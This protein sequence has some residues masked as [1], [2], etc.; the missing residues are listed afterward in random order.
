MGE[1]AFDLLKTGYSR[2]R[3][4]KQS[5][6]GLAGLQTI[7]AIHPDLAG[8][9]IHRGVDRL[10][11]K[12]GTASSL[13]TISKGSRVV[14]INPVEVTFCRAT[15]TCPWSLEG[16]AGYTRIYFS[17]GSRQVSGGCW[18]PQKAT[19]VGCGK[20]KLLW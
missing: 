5:E 4:A 17:G 3:S 11:R 12:V 19:F 13:F 14:E 10:S 9:G 8:H 18:L 2:P 16:H 7:L 6:P 20:G 15:T 1:G